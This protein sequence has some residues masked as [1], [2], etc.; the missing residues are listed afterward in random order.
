MLLVLAGTLYL[1]FTLQTVFWRLWFLLVSAAL[2]SALAAQ[3]RKAR[4]RADERGKVEP[5]GPEGVVAFMAPWV[6]LSYAAM[7]Y[8]V[9]PRVSEQPTDIPLWILITLAVLLAVVQ[10]GR[11]TALK[12]S[13]DEISEVVQ[14]GRLRRPRTLWRRISR[15]VFG[16]DLPRT[17]VHAL[18]GVHFEVAQGMVGILGPNGAGKTTLLRMLAGILDPSVGRITLGGVPLEK[19]RRYLA[20]WVGYLPQDFGL[21][22]DL[23]ARNG[24]ASAWTACS[25]RSVWPNAPTR[26]SAASPAECDSGSPWPARY[27]GCRR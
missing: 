17:Q 1:A 13:R 21:P 11:R 19:L 15:R 12:L 24:A 22:E 3:V 9:L 25:K 8:Y 10:S 27:S 7:T 4:G 16:L 26:R 5:G 20:R 23:S 6:A 2:T 14:V 18:A